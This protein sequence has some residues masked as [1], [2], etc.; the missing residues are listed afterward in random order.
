MLGKN[1]QA[2]RPETCINFAWLYTAIHHQIVTE[3]MKQGMKRATV[4]SIQDEICSV[5]QASFKNNL[6][7]KVQFFVKNGLP[8]DLPKG[9]FIVTWS[10]MYVHT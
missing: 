2:G 5:G 4:Q 10:Y 3:S 8:H 7:Q 6:F 1:D 9:N